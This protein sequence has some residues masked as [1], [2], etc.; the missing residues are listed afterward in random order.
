MFALRRTWDELPN[1]PTASRFLLCLVELLSTF[2]V[3]AMKAGA[4]GPLS[5]PWDKIMWDPRVPRCPLALPSPPLASSSAVRELEDGVVL[6]DGA[7]SWELWS[8]VVSQA[9]PSPDLVGSRS[10]WSSHREMRRAEGHE[11]VLPLV[12]GCHVM[13]RVRDPAPP[14]TGGRGEGEQGQVSGGDGGESPAPPPAPASAE[15]GIVE[16]VVTLG[17]V[18]GAGRRVRWLKTLQHEVVRWGAGGEYDVVQVQLDD[19]LDVVKTFPTPETELD[20]AAKYRFAQDH[21]FGVLLRFR[22]HTPDPEGVEALEGTLEWPDFLATTRVRGHRRPDGTVVIREEELLAGSRDSD[23]APRF[24]T[25]AWQPGTVFELGIRVPP[26]SNGDD[27]A[28]P[29]GGFSVPERGLH[30]TY[31]KDVVLD[32]HSIAVTG[33]A[34]L[35]KDRLF[36]FDR[37]CCASCIAVSED[38]AAATGCDGDRRDHRG[39]VF[40]TVGFSSGVHYWEVRVEVADHGSVFIGVAEKAKPGS[41]KQKRLSRWQGWGFVNYRATLHGSTE[42]V[43]GEHFQA[44]DTI[45]VRLDMD[46]GRVSFYLDGMKYGEHI[47]SDLGPA[48]DGIAANRARLQPRTLWPVI[49]LRRPMDRVVVTKKWVSNAGIHPV[50]WLTDALALTTVAIRTGQGETAAASAAPPRPATGGKSTPI[51]LPHRRHNHNQSDHVPDWLYEDAWRLWGRWRESRW[52][53]IATRGC[54]AAEDSF[55]PSTVDVDTSPRACAAAS[56]R[57]GLRVP[58][59]SGDR[60]KI[61]RTGGRILDQPEEAA[62]LGA[63]RG[64]LWYRV[65]SQRGEAASLEGASRPWCWTTSDIEGLELVRRSPATPPEIE[66]RLRDHRLSRA[67]EFW[68]G[69]LQSV[70]DQGAIVR[71]GIEID[72]SD[73]LGEV[74]RHQVVLALERRLNSSGIV[75]FLVLFKT[76]EGTWVRGW[77]SERIRGSVDVLIV[78]RIPDAEARACAGEENCSELLAQLTDVERADMDA[79]RGLLEDMDPA[80]WSEDTAIDR[81]TSDWERRL[82]AACGPRA[83]EWLAKGHGAGQGDAGPQDSRSFRTLAEARTLKDGAGRHGRVAWSIDADEQL[84]QTVQQWSDLL[85]VTPGNLVFA[86][87]HAI[88]QAGG[89]GASAVVQGLRRD[90]AEHVADCVRSKP[91]LSGAS[92]DELLARA[93]VLLALNARAQRAL[94]LVSFSLPEDDWD[95]EHQGVPSLASVSPRGLPGAKSAVPPST[96]A[97]AAWRPQSVGRHLRRI[98]M[99]LFTHTKRQFWDA[100]LQA[101]MTPTPLAHDEYEDPREIKT[102]KINRV[103][104]TPQRLATIRLVSERLRSSVFGQLHRELRSLPRSAFRRAYVGKGHGGQRRAFKV[105]FLGEGVNDYGGP[106]RA[107]FDQVADEVRSDRLALSNAVEAGGETALKERSC[108]I[109]IFVPCPNRSAGLGANQDKFLLLPGLPPAHIRELAG[110]LGKTVGLAVRHGLQMGLDLPSLVWKPLA[111]QALTIHDLEAVDSLTSRTIQRIAEHYQS[112]G[113]SSVG[114]DGGA[115]EA[116]DEDWRRELNFT[117]VLS[118][119][120]SVSLSPDG[121]QQAVD[122]SNWQDFVRALVACRLQ[123]SLPMLHALRTGLASVLPVDLFPMFSPEELEQLV[124]GSGDVDVDLLQQC[125]EYEEVSPDAPH[126]RFFWEVLREMRGEEREAFLRFVWARSRMPSAATDFPMNFKL[127]APQGPAETSP[128]QWL[129][130]AQTCFFSLSLPAYTTKEILREKLL[131]AIKNSPNMDADVRL[132]SAEGWGEA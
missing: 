114:S 49:G 68:S 85:G 71:D 91:L 53:R 27:K 58:L 54:T 62:V 89:G 74:H 31:T 48:F 64:L 52:L 103:R 124:C 1:L 70:F 95:E 63:F 94:P 80:A 65:E 107:V 92:P 125:T 96:A 25:N 115:D 22:A 86:H 14:P 61:L 132:H 11:E 5:I 73:S 30:G 33:R 110:F 10:G 32:G 3:L 9:N 20:I 101:T 17:G 60:V 24:G 81:I 102:I 108:L 121:A 116:G 82:V 109:P 111:G 13:R 113:S 43:Y 120:T 38:G 83:E 77:I 12:P 18:P 42:R 123:E 130:H 90:W 23:W 2:Q 15:V 119:G 55:T 93:A 37:H 39:V 67:P 99:L 75:R 40:G 79:D 16:E 106:Y 84:C 47:V 57:T 59:L 19:K 97:A 66:P 98:K 76:S 78:K 72:S 131:F 8:G 50:T 51:A 21:Y 34:S 45:G 56:A 105:K 88:L 28:S 35:C 112:G 36:S 41:S 118:D 117:T 122:E 87:L 44:N 26:T 29:V 7:G 127:Q 69:W 4:P 104:A 46:H 128:D 100:V 126:I 6:S 129:P